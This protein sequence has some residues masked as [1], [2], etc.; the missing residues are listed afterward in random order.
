M[1]QAVQ[2]KAINSAAYRVKYLSFSKLGGACDGLIWHR[3][4]NHKG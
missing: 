1:P 2:T 3:L 4:C